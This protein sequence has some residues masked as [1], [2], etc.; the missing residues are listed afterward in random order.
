MMEIESIQMM[1][2][3]LVMI[4]LLSLMDYAGCI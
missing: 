4:A 2:M 1:R 3:S